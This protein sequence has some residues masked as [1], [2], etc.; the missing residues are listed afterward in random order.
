MSLHYD[1]KG[2]FFTDYVTKEA[3]RATIQTVINRIVGNIYVRVGERVSDQ[4]NKAGPFLPVTD[5]VVLDP[6][7]SEIYQTNFLAV[8]LDQVV[9]MM[10]EEIQD[11][12]SEN[13]AS[14]E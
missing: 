4:L 5:A 7:G 6:S 11:E 3:V 12:N 1:E 8:N 10:T 2:K 9:W 13:P 14:E